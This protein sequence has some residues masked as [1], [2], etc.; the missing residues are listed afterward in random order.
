[1]P[2]TLAVMAKLLLFIDTHA[3]H[4][5]T[6]RDHV[7]SLTRLSNH[8]IYLAEYRGAVQ[9]AIELSHFDVIVFH[10]SVILAQVGRAPGNLTAHCKGFRGLKVVLIQ[11]EYR[12]INDTV[13]AAV[14]L[15]ICVIFTVV[16]SE[17]IDVI[18]G[19]PGLS[20]V[21]KEQTLTGFVPEQLLK[22]SVPPFSQ[23]SIDVG[24]RGRSVPFWL[25][26][27]AQE[28][29]RIGERFEQDAR[30]YELTTD[31]SSDEKSRL[32]GRRWIDFL[33]RCKAVLGTESGAS[34]CD[35]TG[36]IQRRV[37][38]Y[39]ADCPNA[40]FE[41]VQREILTKY[42]GKHLI[43]VISPRCF[44]A[45]ALRTLMILY[46]GEYSGLLEPWRH[47]VPLAKD[48]SNMAE[49][50]S[51]LKSPEQAQQII[52]AAYREVGCVQRESN[53]L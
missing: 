44:E 9:A 38:S 25:G 11:D 19:H 8:E 49:V 28:K 13:R 34:I 17:M 29:R 45:A 7:R 3:M 22:R 15:N 1:M 33:T 14:D 47:Y 24:Y 36:D 6:V 41:D 46:P 18:Y 16:N 40:T 4:T 48:H 30:R 53:S 51:V 50:V 5:G 31:I 39:V 20:K 52:D 35:F 37:D 42:D 12:W 27:F 10:Y 32:Y 23:R 21:R 43:N 2:E 26:G